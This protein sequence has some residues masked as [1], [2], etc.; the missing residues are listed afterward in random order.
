MFRLLKRGLQ[1]GLLVV[2]ITMGSGCSGKDGSTH[3]A[4][5]KGEVSVAR[6]AAVDPIIFSFGT[7]RSDYLLNPYAI[8]NAKI[9]GDTLLLTV[10]YT[11]GCEDHQF[12]LI[13][14]NDFLESKPVQVDLLLTHDA[15]KDA[16]KTLVKEELKFSLASI[17]EEYRIA[18]R[19]E[20]GSL[21]L[22]LQDPSKPEGY[23][24][25][26]YAF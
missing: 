5:P 9:N 1:V 11:G 25:V 15:N 17:K 3:Y 14:L 4:V 8:E 2:F 10:S 21:N 26:G 24:Q 12:E 7:T 16:C 13:A 19:T 18:F 20:T 23:L 6:A 22:R